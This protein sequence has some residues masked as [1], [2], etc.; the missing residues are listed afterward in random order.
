MLLP[1]G[2]VLQSYMAGNWY[3]ILHSYS[4]GIFFGTAAWI[5]FL[6]AL[7]LSCR[8]RFLDRLFG[9]DRLIQTHKHFASAAVVSAFFHAF[10]KMQFSSRITIQH[11]TGFLGYSVIILLAFFSALVMS[12]FLFTEFLSIE[13]LKRKARSLFRYSAMKFL[14]NGLP[15]ALVII[16][17]HILI[18]S[19]TAEIAIR[20]VLIL[21]TGIPV[22]L[23]W[24]FHK[25]A[26]PLFSPR[27]EIAQISTH[28]D[29]LFSV[30]LRFA[31]PFKY[32]PGQ[33]A[34]FRVSAPGLKEEHPFTLSG[35]EHSDIT[36]LI[37]K[38]GRWTNALCSAAAGTPVRMDGFYGKFTF[39]SR[40]PML[41]IAGGV[42]ITPFLAKIRSMR[43]ADSVFP[44]PVRLIWTAAGRQEM[45]FA[46]VFESHAV[47][48]EMFE[49][50][51]VRTRD[52]DSAGRLSAERIRGEI[53]SLGNL[54]NLQP[55]VWFCGSFSLRG[56]VLKG[57]KMAGLSG[58]C[59]HYE[60]FSV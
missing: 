48:D 24:L 18:A 55:S 2:A 28:S 40:K 60:E 52:E 13:P 44:F 9:Q 41:W 33:F 43:E 16:L 51:P 22:L 58:K 1:A 54:S 30:T 6:A 34:Y 8:I 10:F 45:P 59:F 27:G 42:G 7:V 21:I 47:R 25:I 53:E 36:L 37:K 11:A 46:D 15:A 29:H 4:L 20:S 57:V 3:S 50:I 19:S 49:F 39:T 38:E 31:N 56:T 32:V 35:A 5:L 14:H 12:R 23:L 17:I 26:R